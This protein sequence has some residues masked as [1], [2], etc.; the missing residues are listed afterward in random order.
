M[1]DYKKKLSL[2]HRE[3]VCREML[4]RI[5]NEESYSAEFIEGHIQKAMPKLHMLLVRHEEQIMA[6]LADRLLRHATTCS[7][8]QTKFHLPSSEAK[9]SNMFKAFL[10]GWK[11]TDG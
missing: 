6:Y 2:T 3:Q 7:L 8:D 4:V 5:F 9:L 1:K 11:D 10:E